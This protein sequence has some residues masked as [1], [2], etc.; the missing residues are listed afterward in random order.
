MAFSGPLHVCQNLLD[1]NVLVLSAPVEHLLRAVLK[2]FA[3]IHSCL[4]AVSKSSSHWYFDIIR[5]ELSSKARHHN[6]LFN[7]FVIVT[8]VSKRLELETSWEQKI[9]HEQ[10]TP[11]LSGNQPHIAVDT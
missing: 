11:G 10:I 6:V 7:S 2:V 1:W 9:M 5:L 8:V 3:D 4:R